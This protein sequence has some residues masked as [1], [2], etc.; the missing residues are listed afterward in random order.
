MHQL[1]CQKPRMNHPASLPVRKRT[2]RTAFAALVLAL[3]AFGS[4]NLH[5]STPD[6]WSDDY[7][8]SMQ[9]AN[10]SGKPAL[11][12]LTGSD[13]CI[14]C[15]RL[16]AEILDTPEFREYAAENLQL[17]YLD[18]PKEDYRTKE[19]AK[20]NAKLKDTFNIRGY[21]TVVLLDSEG[22][23]LARL[24]YMKGGPKTFIRAIK[25]ALPN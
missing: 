13:W 25:S 23:E 4:A 2:F 16:Y 24:G 12:L 14:W 10:A 17:I 22:K 5:A 15:K 20:Q 18:Y 9:A 3:A 11:V 19:V 1:F 6:G 7:K 21:P 8:A